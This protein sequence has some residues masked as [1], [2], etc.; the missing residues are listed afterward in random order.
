VVIFLAEWG[1]L[2]QIL[3]ANLAAKYHA[4]TWVAVESVLALWT[5]AGIA[6]AGGQTLMRFFRVASARKT[7]AVVFVTLAG[8][9]VWSAAQRTLARHWL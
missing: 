5:V 6:V 3:P 9:S 2:T 1:D 8:Y 4:P 7:T